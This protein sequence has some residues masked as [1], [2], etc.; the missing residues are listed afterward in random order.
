MAKADILP[1]Q[2]VTPENT[3]F[4]HSVFL[5]L[6]SVVV[7]RSNNKLLVI[8]RQ[9]LNKT[10]KRY[11]NFSGT[12][13]ILIWKPAVKLLKRPFFEYTERLNISN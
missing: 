6:F 4:T 3:V 13:G 12:N 9:K 7:N 10:L 5:F 11:G 2:I 1:L 8:L